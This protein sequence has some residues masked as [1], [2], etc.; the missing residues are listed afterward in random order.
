YVWDRSARLA[1]RLATVGLGQTISLIESGRWE[2]AVAAGVFSQ[3]NMDSRTNDLINA[4]YL[5]GLPV[6]YRRGAFAT[7]FQVYHQSAQVRAW[8]PAWSLVSGLE[9]TAPGSAWHWSLLLKAYTG[10]TP[11]GQFYRDRLSS[12]G[13]GISFTR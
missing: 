12:I 3:F 1:S 7:R 2:V 6:V 10:P 9:L 8:Q 4:D 13:G 5:V 11:F